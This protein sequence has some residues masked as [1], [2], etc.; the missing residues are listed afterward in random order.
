MRILQIIQKK[1]L[2]GAENF[3]AQLSGHLV[4]Q[5]HEVRLVALLDGPD[6][7]PFPGEIEVIGADVSRRFSDRKGWKRLAGIV[8]AF[9]P[10]IVQ[11]NAGDTLKYAV[12]SRMQYRWEAP[13]VF[14][15]ASVMSRY[16][17]NPFTRALNRFLLAQVDHVVSVSGAS[18]A[19]LQQW[20]SL[21]DEQ[22]T[23]LPVGIERT[24]VVPVTHMSGPGPHLVHVGG[25][26]FEK[27]HQGLLRIFGKVRQHYPDA[28]LWLVGDGPLR[29]AVMEQAE[30]EGLLAHV[31]FT[32]F[33]SA[34]LNY[35]AAAR[36]LLLPS[37]IEGFPAVIP[38]AFYCGTPVVAY[39]VGGIG[40]VL[41]E[42]ETGFPVTPGREDAFADAVVR[43]LRLTEEER[44][45]LTSRARRRV[46][47]QYLNER[48][49]AEFVTLYRQIRGSGASTPAA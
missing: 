18:R 10:D 24:E 19:D 42:G 38:E 1:Q 49:A 25:F 5:G 31:H 6:T 2:R 20:T 29:G 23:V 32:G 41:T 22:V 21:R 43:A 11:A 26:S 46:E 39:T 27:N 48:I 34:P 40:P 28:Q 3:A 44:H 30:Q 45:H 15:N 33:V 12:L 17:T 37:I 36:V 9:Q 4:R 8:R 47:E 16:L 35:I 7:L 13:L 14:R